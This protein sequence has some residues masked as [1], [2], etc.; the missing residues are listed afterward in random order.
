VGGS[1]G[2]R[3]ITGEKSPV[4]DHRGNYR[5]TREGGKSPGGNHLDPFIELLLCLPET[6]VV[7][8]E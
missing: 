2:Q 7:I 8:A 4:G 5:R 1:Q 3:E 6:N